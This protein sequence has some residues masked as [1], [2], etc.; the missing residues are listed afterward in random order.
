MKKSF[1]S[2]FIILAISISASAQNGIQTVKGLIIDKQSEMPLIGAT[3]RLI[4][5][6]ENI[7]TVTDFNGEFVLDNVPIGRQAFEINFLGYE[8]MII[9]NVEVASGKETFLNVSLEESIIKLNE[10]VIKASA[11]KDKSINEMATVSTRQFSMEEVNRFSGGR[12]D[13]ARLAG[14]FAGVSTADDSR[15]DIV[16]RL[17]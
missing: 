2:I 15:N 6:D 16:I 13:V 5:Q 17:G 14:N 10:V 11:E 8:P 3:I 1:L 12:S 9:P 4:I 7:A